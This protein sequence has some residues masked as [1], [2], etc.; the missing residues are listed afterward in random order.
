MNV[1]F[2]TPMYPSPRHAIHGLFVRELAEA[3]SDAGVDVRVAH[4]QGSLVWPFSLLKRYR[5]DGGDAGAAEPVPV[6]RHGVK[7]LP[8]AMGTVP[9]APRW[10]RGVLLRIQRTWPDFHPDI[11]HAHT[12]IPGLLVARPAAE[13][14]RSPLV[15]TVHGADARVW[16]RRRRARRIILET[17]RGGTPI[18][19]VSESL[20]QTLVKAGAT[21]S[22]LQTIHN[23]MDLSKVHS[24]PNPLAR[25]YA[26]KTLVL[27]VGNLKR[28][29]GFDLFIEAIAQVRETC[30]SIHGVIVGGGAERQRLEKLARKRN[31]A[32]C[33]ELVG[34]RS[35]S[36]TMEYMDQCTVFCLPSWSEGFGIV[37]LEAMAH[38]KPIIA[39]EGQ[40]IASILREAGSG[41]LVPPQDASALVAALRRLL[42]HPEERQEM[43]ERGRRIVQ[44]R[45]SWARSA[46][47]VIN[48][49]R[50][51]LDHGPGASIH[52]PTPRGPGT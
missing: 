47:E 8:M 9:F 24:G 20:K 17:S 36:E 33:L 50:D 16:L 19:C 48:A 31:V 26:G 2:V 25:R 44:E 4:I 52:G 21:S 45:F 42:E 3:L 7:V 43:G 49:Y 46:R 23:G 35:P 14:F 40:G 38:G 37:Y 22:A 32:D 13:A 18:L 41:L 12:I 30:P 51:A 10:G 5:T 1:L 39:V 29:K 11:I 6:L 15:V 34:A 28:S 27:G